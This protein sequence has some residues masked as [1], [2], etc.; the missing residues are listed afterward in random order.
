[1]WIRYAPLSEVTELDV[2]RM[3]SVGVKGP[4]W[5][6]QAVAKPMA[7]RGGGSIVNIASMAA[8]RGTANAS[9]YSAAKGA[10]VSMTRQLAYELGP[11]KIRVNAIAPGTIETPGS[12]AAMSEDARAYRIERAPLGRLG[13]PADIAE[14]VL[15]LGGPAASFV[16]GQVLKMDGGISIAM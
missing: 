6:S 4:L 13:Q 15:Y 11:R 5:V 2:E 7:E 1:M 3:L 10:V 14:A 12:L 8:Y 16:T 9:V